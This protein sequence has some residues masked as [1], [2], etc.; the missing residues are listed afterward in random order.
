MQRHVHVCVCTHSSLDTFL[1]A[2]DQ[3]ESDQLRRLHRLVFRPAPLLHRLA[4][5]LAS[6]YELAHCSTLAPRSAQKKLKLASPQKP[7]MSMQ[8]IEHLLSLDLARPPSQ[9]VS[10]WVHT[11]EPEGSPLC[12]A[13]SSSHSGC[14]TV[15]TSELLSSQSRSSEGKLRSS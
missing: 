3:L 8:K 2:P 4:R 9:G 10:P 6:A 11:T 15:Y 13:S 5:K 1:A 12:A 7:S 14:S